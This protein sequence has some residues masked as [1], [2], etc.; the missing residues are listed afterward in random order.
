VKRLCGW[1]GEELGETALGS[2]PG[3]LTSHGIC[4]SCAH[5]VWSEVGT[6][7]EEFL[8]S[9]NIPTLLVD[10]DGRVQSANADALD[11]V[12][13]PRHEVEG[14]LGGD[15]FQCVNAGLPG[16]CGRTELCSACTVR[17][18][19]T[20]TYRTG[21]T[22]VRVPAVL[23][24]MEEETSKELEFLLTTQRVGSRVLVRIEPAG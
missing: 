24:V 1:C 6:P 2:D 17:N 19:V 14:V 9:L 15:V 16:G 3:G 7:L 20:H 22:K 18:T 10:E 12:G 5:Q 8:T 23:D 21:E 13:K 11:F 4:E